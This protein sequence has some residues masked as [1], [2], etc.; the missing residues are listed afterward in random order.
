VSGF[1]L[2]VME[3]GRCKV[4]TENKANPS[5]GTRPK[6]KRGGGGKIFREACQTQFQ[7]SKEASEARNQYHSLCSI[8]RKK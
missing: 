3:L 5:M 6:N 1:L 4:L 7:R 8:G 2:Q